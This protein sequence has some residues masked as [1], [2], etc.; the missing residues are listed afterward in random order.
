MA[1]DQPEL[2]ERIGAAPNGLVSHPRERGDLAAAHRQ[3]AVEHRQRHRHGAGAARDGL[4]DVL[5]LVHVLD[6]AQLLR[7]E[8]RLGTHVHG[9][10]VTDRDDSC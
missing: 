8:G 3:L 4:I 1:I 2:G 10:M 7:S 5:E 9:A 6:P